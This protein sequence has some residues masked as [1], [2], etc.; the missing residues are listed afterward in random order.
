VIICSTGIALALL[1]TFLLNYAAQHAPRPAGL[2][3]VGLT[4]A[5]PALD[6]GV[7][8]IAVL[9]LVL[10]FGTKAGLAPLHAWLPDAHSQAPAPVSALMS[11]VLISV[12]F[13]A[14][15][16]VKII[17]DA[18]L[19]PDF[20]R[21]L[22]IVLSLASITLAASLL[23]AQKDY[24]RML[25]YSSIEN[26]GLLALGAAIGSPLA[27]AAVLLHI[28]GH[29]LAKSVLFL[30]AGRVLQLTGSSRIDKVRGLAARDPVLAGCLGFGVL[31]IIAFPPFSLFA[32]ELG[33]ST[34]G[35]AG[36]LGWV[37]AAALILVL[38]IAAAL[39]GHT[40]RMLLGAPTQNS[41]P[42]TADHHAAAPG[43][44]AAAITAVG[45]ADKNGT[46]VAGV[47]TGSSV[48]VAVAPP[49]LA[50]ARRRRRPEADS[51]ALVAALVVC[52][53]LGLTLGPLAPLL[54][55]ATTIV[56]GT[57]P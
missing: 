4:A 56:T 43:P 9:L 11:G 25:A 50:P 36:G 53:V 35:F 26:M 57:T 51:Y 20:T 38:V 5:A 21:A 14:I 45:T 40:S 46:S 27:V 52:G 54:E 19:G 39:V 16:R 10:G 7:T 1:G 33:I 2:D 31:A 23:L 6:P 28:L 49:A 18:A 42:G 29:G 44:A 47:P 8:R 17:A 55:Q 3:W 32:S 22:L 24:K 15:L 12:A 41:A 37:T 48:A 13:Y 34:A 30:S